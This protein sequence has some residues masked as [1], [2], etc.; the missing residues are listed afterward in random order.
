MCSPRIYSAFSPYL[1]IFNKSPVKN[2]VFSGPG[3]KDSQGLAP[4]IPKSPSYPPL[5][6]PKF[7]HNKVRPRRD[8]RTRPRNSNSPHPAMLTFVDI[9][10]H[11]ST[12]NFA[13][14]HLVSGAPEGVR[15]TLPAKN[16]VGPDPKKRTK[17]DLLF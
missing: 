10:P 14:L 6:P 15:H 1:Q 17:N 16:P 3:P 9:F 7:C 2:E 12:E 5:F 11:F 13:I 8:T 4:R